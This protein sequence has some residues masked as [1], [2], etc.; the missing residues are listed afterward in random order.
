M[1]L[2]KY[3]GIFMILTAIIHNIVGFVM[4]WSVLQDIAR[5]GFVNTVNEQMD[6][7]AIFW[8]LFSGFIMLLIGMIMHKM[9][10]ENQKPVPNYIAYYLLVISVI[11]CIIMPASGFWI[12]LPQCAIIIFSRK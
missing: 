11:G 1:K 3:S 6:R 12:V 10:R 7:S 4:G 5:D 9:I 8:F 2:W